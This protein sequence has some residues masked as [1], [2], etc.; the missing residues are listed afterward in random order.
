MK[1][2]KWEKSSNNPAKLLFIQ[3][4][5]NTIFATVKTIKKESI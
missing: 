5:N 1:N 2:V 4:Q 3:M